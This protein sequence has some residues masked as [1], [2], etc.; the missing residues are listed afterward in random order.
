MGGKELAEKFK[1]L[2]PDAKVLFISG[3]TDEAIFHQASL[4][5]GEPFLLKPFSILT[6][7]KKVR[8]VL[9]QRSI[10]SGSVSV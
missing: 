7:T 3:Y 5:R 10:V 6:L 1:A 2:Y 9:D 4:P 8:E